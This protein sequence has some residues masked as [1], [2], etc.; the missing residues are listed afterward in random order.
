MQVVILVEKNLNAEINQPQL[1]MVSEENWGEKKKDDLMVMMEG[2]ENQVRQN[3]SDA[4]EILQ[5]GDWQILSPGQVY[6][7]QGAW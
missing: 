4:Y 7:S 2:E 3:E 6:H 5:L 1:I